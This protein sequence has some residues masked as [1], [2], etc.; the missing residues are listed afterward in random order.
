MAQNQFAGAGAR[1]GANAAYQGAANNLPQAEQYS[2]STS[3]ENK[4][5][6]I[7]KSSFEYAKGAA[8]KYRAEDAELWDLC[9]AIPRLPGI[10]P[11]VCFIFNILLPGV[12]TMICACVGFPEK[13]SK[14]QLTI[15]TVQFLTAVYLVG[16]IFSIYWG[17]LMLQKGI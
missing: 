1:A 17:W 10:W 12:G 13:Y 2:Q 5:A 16:W 8:V 9:T 7:A 6:D 3:N 11:Y 14:T 4:A 15:G